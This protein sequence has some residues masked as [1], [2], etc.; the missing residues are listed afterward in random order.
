[1]ITAIKPRKPSEAQRWLIDCA[2]NAMSEG[3]TGV[4][5]MWRTPE[6]TIAIMRQQ[7]WISLE[8]LHTPEKRAELHEE[9]RQKTQSA[10]DLLDCLDNWPTALT[11]LKA[12]ERLDQEERATCYRVTAQGAAAVGRSL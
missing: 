12:V 2:L 6:P 9:I 1:V 11:A 10:R 4:I 5:S 3:G 7:G 8:P